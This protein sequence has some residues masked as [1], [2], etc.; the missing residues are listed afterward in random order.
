MIQPTALNSAEQWRLP[1]SLTSHHRVDFLSIDR[2]VVDQVQMADSTDVFQRNRLEA[3]VCNQLK[4][5]IT[6][7]LNF[8]IRADDRVDRVLGIYGHG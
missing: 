5:K 8:N 4:A 2:T 7:D 3:G 1:G 6:S